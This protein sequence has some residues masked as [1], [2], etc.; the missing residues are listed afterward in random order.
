MLLDNQSIVINTIGNL[1][2]PRLDVMV[3][4]KYENLDCDLVEWIQL[5]H[6]WRTTVG[7]YE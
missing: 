2:T 1:Y 4:K 7:C 5:A 6:D 3:F